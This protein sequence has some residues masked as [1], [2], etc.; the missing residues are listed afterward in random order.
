[1]GK[2]IEFK[3]RDRLIKLGCVISAIRRMRGMTQEQLADR[4]NISRSYLSIIE[5]PYK[6]VSFSIDI[7]Y[8]IADALEVKASDLLDAKLPNSE[9]V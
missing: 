1:M 3:N 7:L 4:A 8:D 5:A 2:E 9:D 6:A